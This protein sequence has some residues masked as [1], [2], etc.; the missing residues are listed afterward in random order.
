VRDRSGQIE[1]VH[2]ETL[3]VLLLKQLQ[4]QQ[5]QLRRLQAQVRES[6]KSRR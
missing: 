4:E 3:N 1:T 5:V 2:H 6:M